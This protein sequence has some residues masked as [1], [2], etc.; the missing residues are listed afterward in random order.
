MKKLIVLIF[1]FISTMVIGQVKS[2]DFLMKYN[3]ETNQYDVSLIILEGS[4]SSIAH[5]AQFNAQISIVVPAGEALEITNKYMPLLDNQNYNGS[6]PMEW[7]LANPVYSPEVQPENDFFAVQPKLNNAAFYNNLEEGDVVLLFSFIAGASGQYDEQI[8]FYRNGIDPGY[9][10]AGMQGGDFSNGFTLGGATQL[11]N[12]SSEESCITSIDE[13]LL[14]SVKVYPNPFE[15]QFSL[16]LP[17]GAKSINIFGSDG[18]VYYSSNNK[19]KGV[20]TINSFA[21]PRGVY[22]VNIESDKGVAIRKIVKF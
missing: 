11:F 2:V 10:A 3:C 14:T 15:H 4:A 20:L 5:R 12:D 19:S 7:G 8:R 22:Y 21:F 1:T 9:E 16:E 17:N 6:Q 18:K 13:R